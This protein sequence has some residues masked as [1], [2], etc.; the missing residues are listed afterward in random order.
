ML[1]P[2]KENYAGATYARPEIAVLGGLRLLIESLSP[3]AGGLL[4]SVPYFGNPSFDLDE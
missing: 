2:A 1:N 3:K 4:E